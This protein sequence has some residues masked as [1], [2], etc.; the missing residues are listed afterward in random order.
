MAAAQELF[1]EQGISA[2]S[3]SEVAQHAG[4]SPV[5]IFKYFGDKMTLARE[6]VLAYID[7][8]MGHYED[9]LNRD[10]PFMEKMHL[11]MALKQQGISLFGGP[12]GDGVAWDDP[13][14]RQMLKEVS[15]GRA[16]ALYTKFIE[17]GK[18]EG[19]IDPTIPNEAILDFFFMFVTLLDRP[20]FLQQNADYLMGLV[21]L[22]FYGLIGK[23]NP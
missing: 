8:T 10:I 20:D 14:L 16:V 19:V 9:M 6:M 13:V 23:A 4:V 1:M 11:T 12:Q 15:T 18:R 17:D 21:K 22:S 2:V 3:V 5:T 7:A